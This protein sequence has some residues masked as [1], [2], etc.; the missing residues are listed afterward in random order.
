MTVDGDWARQ[1]EDSNQV[2]PANLAHRLHTWLTQSPQYKNADEQEHDVYGALR[3]S[4]ME[5]PKD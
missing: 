5:Q 3:F 1:T 2:A 4:I